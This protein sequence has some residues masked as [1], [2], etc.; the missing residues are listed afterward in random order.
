MHPRRPRPLLVAALASALVAA[1][2]ASALDVP[3]ADYQ[4]L[5]QRVAGQE[6]AIESFRRTLQDLRMEVARMRSTTEQLKPLATAPRSFATQEQFQRLAEQVRGVERNRIA[7]R[8]QILGAIEGL[9]ALTKAPVAPAG[10]SRPAA[11]APSRKAPPARR[12]TAP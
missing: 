7:D 4:R 1:P 10:G 5:L 8:Q 12:K 11:K 6:A 3:L 2:S 9:R